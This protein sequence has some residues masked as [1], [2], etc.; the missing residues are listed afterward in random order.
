MGN[1]IK[2][3]REAKNLVASKGADKALSDLNDEI[4]DLEMCDSWRMDQQARWSRLC[5]LRAEVSEIKRLTTPHDMYAVQEAFGDHVWV[6]SDR[7]LSHNK[8]D[9]EWHSDER[10][11]DVIR[12]SLN[13]EA[14]W[15]KFQTVKEK[16]KEK[17]NGDK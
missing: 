3:S 5:D 7:S 2:I 11:A 15:A 6:M 16:R 10:Y 8:D 1:V 14:G 4:W 13:Q 17:L 12:E 9:A